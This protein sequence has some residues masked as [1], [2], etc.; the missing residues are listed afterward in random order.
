MTSQLAFVAVNSIADS[1][2]DKS[3]SSACDVLI[4]AIAANDNKNTA[5]SFLILSLFIINSLLFKTLL[6]NFKSVVLKKASPTL[7]AG[8]AF[9]FYESS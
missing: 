6:N 2:F 4:L 5:N 3:I 7:E 9:C 8:L 1:E